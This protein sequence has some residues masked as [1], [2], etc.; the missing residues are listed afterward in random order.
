MKKDTLMHTN[1]IVCF[2]ITI[3]FII[4]SIISY[5][6]NFGIYEKDI[7][8]VSTLAA[9]G[10][11][12]Q[13]ETILSKPV[14]V[15]LTMA[16][17]SLL[18]NF[19]SYEDQQGNDKEYI[20]RLRDYLNAYKEKYTYDS[21]FLVSAKSNRY[22]HF[23]GLDRVLAKGN[24]ENDWYYS[25]LDK[26][27]EFSLNIDNDEASDDVITVFVNCLIKDRDGSTLGIVGIGLKVNYLHD[28]LKEYNKKFDVG[29][30]LINDDGA[31]QVSSQE[32][33]AKN[34]NILQEPPFSK[35][36]NGLLDNHSQK[37]AYWYSSGKKNDYIVSRYIPDLKWRLV[38]EKD[39]SALE[40]RFQSQL[41]RGVLIIILI[42][43][44]VLVIITK[45]I[46]KYKNQI[47]KLTISQEVEYQKLLHQT[48]EGLYE[49]IY[50][51][52][53]T[54]NR[55]G[56]ESTK[57]YFESIGLS[58][59]TPADEALK[60][61][62][63]HQIKEEYVKGYLDRFLPSNVLEAYNNG[64]TNLTYDFLIG[65]ADDGYRWM[66]VNA[67]IFYWNSDKSVRMISYRK[68]I[69]TEKKNEI[70]LIEKSYKD[71]LTGLYNKLSTEDL[72]TELL[73]KKAD[74]KGEYAFILVDIDNFKGINDQLGHSYGDLVIQEFAAEL[75]TQFQETDIVG[76]IGGDEFVAVMPYNSLADLK[77]KLERL[78]SKLGRKQYSEKQTYPITSSVGVALFP[79]HGTVYSA[80]Y[81]KSDQALFFSKN[82]GKNTFSIFGEDWSDADNASF[83]VNQRDLQALLDTST[84]GIAKIACV[85]GTFK[86]LFFN[87]KRALLTGTPANVLS[88]ADFNE[89][90]QVHP[91]DVKQA[92]KVFGD[93]LECKTPFE[94]SIRMKY[95]D[96]NYF[97]VSLRGIFVHE[98]Y[99]NKYPI[100]YAIYTDNR[101]KDKKRTKRL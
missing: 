32:K 94:L 78:C 36:K 4:T 88:S 74:K 90:N 93:A 39:T 19:L 35:L 100:F 54:H 33:Y 37:Q 31:V 28:I 9:D 8:H 67:R 23:N 24:P 5:K 46:K 7:E 51:F 38:V 82:H 34:K 72:I 80:L 71:P 86:M 42:T 16:N 41:F 53:I 83:R 98:L 25:F 73:E 47:V 66:R 92:L 69:D 77:R 55:A 58:R 30:F 75:K 21:V 12:N 22:Y 70:K 17:D 76:R 91:D 65:D 1:I 29:A 57:D 3:G 10:I 79:Q 43:V 97:P 85:D 52:D 2:I 61:I 40:K 50:E 27:E 59:D 44:A 101:K 89:L 6:S 15:S 49:S 62:A 11:Y 48:T 13:L 63:G 95:K 18:K 20:T 99:E 45:L 81:E 60:L 64:I 87:A 84:D 68:N 26:N 96:G 14:H 56:G